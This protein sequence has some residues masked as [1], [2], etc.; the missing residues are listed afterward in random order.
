MPRPSGVQMRK[1]AKGEWRPRYLPA[2]DNGVL[3]IEDLIDIVQAYADLDRKVAKKAVYAIFHVMI[4]RLKKL[5]R[6]TVSKFGSFRPY[7]KKN[8]RSYH[9]VY[10]TVVDHPD[11][12]AIR[13]EESANLRL[14]L[15]APEEMR[16]AN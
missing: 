14:M 4:Q 1:T 7:I 13:F 16:D 3:T 10:K 2:E 11:K 12:L 9:I 8:N 15:N 6:V 5:E